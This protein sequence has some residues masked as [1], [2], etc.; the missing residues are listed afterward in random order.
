MVVGSVSVILDDN[1]IDLF[2]IKELDPS[3]LE[4]PAQAICC[5]L[6]IEQ[7]TVW[8]S[9]TKERFETSTVDKCLK[10]TVVKD[11]DVKLLVTMR[12]E[13]GSLSLNDM[14]SQKSSDNSV[15]DS[16]KVIFMRTG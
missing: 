14:F 7:P 2:R 13:E 6:Q 5:G 12:D 3:L 10:M 4:L 15:K 8:D 9:E 1:F 16:V 11:L